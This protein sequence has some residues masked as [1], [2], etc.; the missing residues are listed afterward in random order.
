MQLTALDW[1]VIAL[2]TLAGVVVYR[3][4]SRRKWKLVSDDT[5][6][7]AVPTADCEIERPN[8]GR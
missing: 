4:L 5:V 7:V 8:P 1:S 6:E 3:D 2:A